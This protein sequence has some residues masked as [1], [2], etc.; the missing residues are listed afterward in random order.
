MRTLK[1]EVYTVGFD[2][3]VRLEIVSNERQ[4]MFFGGAALPAM[5]NLRVNCKPTDYGHWSG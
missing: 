5:M 1:L 2:G 3:S 4:S